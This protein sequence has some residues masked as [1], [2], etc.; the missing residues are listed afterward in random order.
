MITG[1][2]SLLGV[3][4]GIVLFFLKQKAKKKTPREKYDKDMEKMDRNIADGDGLN[5]SAQFEQLR[6]ENPKRH[7]DSSRPG[8]QEPPERKL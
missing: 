2:I 7:S 8:N 1:I 4:A 6:R 5:I 3:I